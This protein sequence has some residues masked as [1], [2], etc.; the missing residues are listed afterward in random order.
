MAQG[1]P[2]MD[3]TDSQAASSVAQPNTSE[4]N[5]EEYCPVCNEKGHQ[6]MKCPAFK[7]AYGTE[8]EVLILMNSV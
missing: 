2:V 7:I 1:N 6:T 8:I 3:L 5:A 4:C